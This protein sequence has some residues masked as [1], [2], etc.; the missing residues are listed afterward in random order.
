[1]IPTF[2]VS[3]DPGVAD[4][5]NGAVV[6]VGPAVTDTGVVGDV[7][8]DVFSVLSQAP[9]KGNAVTI[10]ARQITVVIISSFLFFIFSSL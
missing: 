7:V 5:F 9:S 3:V 6:V 4:V 10:S 8:V 1:M 2:K